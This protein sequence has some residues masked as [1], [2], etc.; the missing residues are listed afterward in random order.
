MNNLGKREASVPVMKVMTSLA[1]TSVA[2]IHNDAPPAP[3]D[4]QRA[5]F[6]FR[7]T[8]VDLT[9]SMQSNL[10]HSGVCWARD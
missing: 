6:A 3:F 10:S 2:L 4:G 7:N 8:P 1:S 5:K 9:A